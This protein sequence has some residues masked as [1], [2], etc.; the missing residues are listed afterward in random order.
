M[1]FFVNCRG[2]GHH[3]YFPFAARVRADLPN[4]LGVT[5]GIHGNFQY[6]PWEVFAEAQAG[7][8]AGGALLGGIVGILGGPLG[9]I[10][11]GLL[12]GGLGRGA[13]QQDVANAQRFNAS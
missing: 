5:C 11:G 12:G 7:G 8:T 3:L 1:R 6:G 10:L 9:V 13:E 2:G 4:P